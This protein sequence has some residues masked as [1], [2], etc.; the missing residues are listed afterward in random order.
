LFKA[1][2]PKLASGRYAIYALLD[3]NQ[4]WGEYHFAIF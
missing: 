3:R 1:V 2:T 4:Q